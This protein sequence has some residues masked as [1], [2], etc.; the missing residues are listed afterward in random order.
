[1]A[2]LSNEN[3]NDL[4]TFKK[5]I[6][7]MVAKNSSNITTRDSRR[8]KDYS[9]EEVNSIINSSSISAQQKLSRNYFYKDGFYKRILLH[10]ATL[11]LYMGIL[12]PYPKN[13]QSL[14][15]DHIQKRYFKAAA[16]VDKLNIAE[17]FTQI[18]LSVLIDG[19]YYGVIKSQNKD[20]L[21]LIDLPCNYCRS[22]FKDLHGNDI[23][24]FNVQY[25]D[26]IIDLSTREGTL[27]SYP[28]EISSF[29]KKYS[30]GK[31][32]S[33]WIKLST[34]K[35]IYFSLSSDGRP[36]F[37]SVIPATIQYDDAVDLEQERALEEI[38]KIIIQKIPHLND[39]T[40][41]FEPPEVEVMHSGAVGMLKK[42]KN[43]SVLTTYADV[44]A[45]ISKT[46]ADSVSN[47]LEKMVKNIYAEAGTS[48]LLFSTESGQSLTNSIL[49][50][51][52][53]MMILGNKYGRFLS[54]ILNSLF[55][56]SNI[57][58]KYNIL[59]ISLFNQTDFITNA[60]KLAQSGYS[61][62]LPA[63]ALGIT[64][65]SLTNLKDLENNILGLREKLIPLSSSY[66]QSANEE[67]N[68]RPTKNVEEKTNT[69]VEKQER[70]DKEGG[71]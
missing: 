4:T 51:I 2:E 58:F 22:R 59:P 5:V 48:P 9:L 68:G 27:K 35:G 30:K 53:L 14:S 42:N 39:G 50:D 65:S 52:N 15:T 36:F 25:F 11:L 70:L 69:T 38:R 32:T 13:G 28:K 17:I 24:E 55:S 62:L 44:D 46:A 71:S 57:W 7:G 45:I 49:D 60:F 12:V 41:L 43:L 1:M 40:L 6:D 64:Q 67:T 34:D 61:F 54:S 29:Y 33:S 26:S 63:A 8:I 66:T 19:C 56:N 21:L 20:E 31:T 16:Y 37:L 23:V 10:Y 18:S 3:I 47:T